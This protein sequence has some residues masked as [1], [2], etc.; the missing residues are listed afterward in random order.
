MWLQIQFRL[1]QITEASPEDRDALLKEL[2]EF[3]H[4]GCIDQNAV[5]SKANVKIKKSNA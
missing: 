4:R 3:A 2:E 1:H 5:L